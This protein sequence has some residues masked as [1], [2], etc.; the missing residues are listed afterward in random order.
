M[1]KFLHRPPKFS[2]G[3]PVGDR[4]SRQSLGFPLS[5]WKCWDGSQILMNPLPPHLKAQQDRQCTYNVTSR[6]VRATTVPV[7]KQEVLHTM[8][9]SYRPCGATYRSHLQGSFFLD[10]LTHEDGTD[11]L[12]RNVG[13][14][15]PFYAA[16]NRKREQSRSHR[17]GSPTSRNVLYS[18][19]VPVA[20]VIQHATRMR[21]IIL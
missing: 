9:V 15:L 21:R 19:C 4:W 20:L 10:Y 12:S 16:W 11:R 1:S 6:R 17:G 18:E 8:I 5:S 14:K 7:E 13:K 2:R 3:P